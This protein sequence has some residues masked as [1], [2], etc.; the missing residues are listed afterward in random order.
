MKLLI[1]FS[2]GFTEIQGSFMTATV[3]DL[4]AF[5]CCWLEVRVI[6]GNGV[7]VA[8]VKV[9]ENTLEIKLKNDK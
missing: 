3:Y 1:A 4:K 9:T 7:G 8:G 5:L 6:T 2:Y